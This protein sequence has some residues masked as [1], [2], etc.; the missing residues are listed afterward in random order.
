MNISW[1]QSEQKAWYTRMLS[2]GAGSLLR[3]ATRLSTS[4]GV[5][6]VQLVGNAMRL[7][8]VGV[9]PSLP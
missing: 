8:H 6:G 2:C 1:G 4:W 3:L 7:A 5:G 9:N